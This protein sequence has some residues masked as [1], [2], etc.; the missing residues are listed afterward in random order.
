VEQRVIVPSPDPE[1]IFEFRANVDDDGFTTNS[2]GMPNAEIPQRKPAGHFRIAFVGDSVSACWGYDLTRDQ[3][4]LNRVAAALDAPGGPRVEGLNFAV[5]GYSILQGVRVAR[6]K[7]PPFEPDLVIAQLALNDPYPSDNFYVKVAPEGRLRVAVLARR[8]L[9]PDFYL[10]WFLVLRNYDAQG[11]ENV[12]KGMQGY[13]ELARQ[14]PPVLAVLFPYASGPQY[15]E[16][17]I[18]ALHA[19]YA[20]AARSAGLPFLDLF[21]AFAASGL[22]AERPELHPD[23][24]GHAVAARALVEELR[25]RGLVPGS[26]A[27]GGA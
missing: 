14:G 21:D 16:W 4:Y 12:R 27:G 10:A 7:V 6:T 20:E 1:L 8:L 15:R 18:D 23:A 25:A 9:R 24:E 26:A 11:W 3:L 22:I 5:N 13:A 17:G 19:G 2:F